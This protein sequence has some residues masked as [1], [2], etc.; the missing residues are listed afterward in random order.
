MNTEKQQARDKLLDELESLRQILQQEQAADHS[1][2]PLP[3]ATPENPFLAAGIRGRLYSR[4]PL[5]EAIHQA[6]VSPS[7][8]K[9]EGQSTPENLINILIDEVIEAFLPDIEAELRRRLQQLLSDP[10]GKR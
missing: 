10:P 6:T 1:A 5:Q 9:A 7:H 4:D 2:Q 8:A 3:S